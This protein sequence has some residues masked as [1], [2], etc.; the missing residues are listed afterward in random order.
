MIFNKCLHLPSCLFIALSF[1]II[2]SLLPH[3]FLRNIL[4]FSSLFYPLKHV[5]SFFVVMN[6]KIKFI[7]WRL[8]PLLYITIIFIIIIYL[9][10]PIL[11]SI[12]H[13]DL[14]VFSLT[15]TWG[16][17]FAYLNFKFLRCH[18]L[19]S[20]KK[21][22]SQNLKFLLIPVNI[23]YFFLIFNSSFLIFFSIVD[24]SIKHIFPFFLCASI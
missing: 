9:L 14:I 5:T 15:F 13:R 12:T 4:S 23:E 11:V 20:F 16:Y 19:L 21:F 2:Y 1:L 7:L 6:S 24:P 8:F 17:T 22:H 18:I 10:F 3:L